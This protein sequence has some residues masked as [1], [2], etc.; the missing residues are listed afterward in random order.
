M[1]EILFRGKSVNEGQWVE[2]YLYRISEKLN[3]FIMLK[4]AK[5]ESYEVAPETVGQ[6]TGLKDKND[7]KIFEGDILRVNVRNT[8]LARGYMTRKAVWTVEYKKRFTQG[9]S[10]YFYGTNRRFSRI[11]SQSTIINTC[12]TVIG[13]IHDNLELLKEC[14]N[15]V[16]K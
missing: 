16:T 3:P 1:R 15:S 2:G 5:G 13:N 6:Y 11:A 12:A 7:T 10:Y 14:E 8:D 4:N 9:Q